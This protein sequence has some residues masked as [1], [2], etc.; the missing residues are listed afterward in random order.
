[1]MKTVQEVVWGLL[2]IGLASVGLLYAVQVIGG[3]AKSGEHDRPKFDPTHI[4]ESVAQM[5]IWVG[6]T[7]IRLSMRISR[8]LLGILAEASA[9]VG[10][11][12][13]ARPPAGPSARER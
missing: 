1:M 2:K 13:L 3:Y 9:D 4:I 5:A 10:E 8:P 7:S 11:W 12:A 6:V